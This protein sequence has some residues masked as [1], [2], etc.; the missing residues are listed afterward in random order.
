MILDY[1]ITTFMNWWFN[2][3]VSITTSWLNILDEFKFNGISLL[4]FI[5]IIG[6]L[7]VLII[8]VLPNFNYDGS[9]SVRTSKE[10]TIQSQ[11]DKLGL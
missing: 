1:D 7:T 3:V 11:S 4:Q 6:I 8:V 2:Q 10:K 5:I 9:S